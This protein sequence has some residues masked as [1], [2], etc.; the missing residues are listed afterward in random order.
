VKEKTMLP[1]L[2]TELDSIIRRH[3]DDQI[4][5]LQRLVRA[6]STNPY[7][8]ERS[9]PADP[10]EREVAHLILAELEQIGLRPAQQG[11]S[12]ERPNVVAR[13]S[14]SRPGHCLILNGHMDTVMPSPLWTKDPFGAEIVGGRLYG[15]GV[16]DMKA[17][18][19]MF[20]FAARALIEAGITLGGDLVLTFVVDEEPGAYSRF[21]SAY[22]LDH[23]LTGTAA[24]VAEPLNNN[25]TIGHRGGYRFKLTVQGEAAHTGL[26]AWERRERGHNAILDMA[27]AMR[28][29]QDPPIPY[30]ET[31]AFP[32]RRPAFT[33]PTLIQ[34]GTAINTVP[35]ECIAYGDV[36]LL[37]GA[38]AE[39][40]EQIIHD[41]LRPLG[42][43]YTLERLLF[44][45][46]VEI[47]PDHPL[48]E[49]LAR[50]TAAITGQ[51]PTRLGCGPWNDGWMFIT[52]GI[53]AICGFGPNGSGVH[54]PDEYVELD[55]LIDTTRL[56][57][58]AI[59][60]YLGIVGTD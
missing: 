7:T 50:Q 55:S 37:P 20:V 46:A 45:P 8:P 3:R 29:L 49:I 24:I 32:G 47:A 40:V 18:L 31:A 4:A 44:V 56:F 38:D 42:L 9:D 39:Q 59:V 48:V 51:T 13:L 6:R 10:V 58:R 36:R 43:N 16:L 35:D 5:F 14:G 33:F 17:S 22:L 11:I 57:A 30:H 52:H 26:P 54:S 27:Q 19:S 12:P 41:R 2:F 15:L 28:A 60:E 1:A 34:G 25:V 21:G 23:G 53:P